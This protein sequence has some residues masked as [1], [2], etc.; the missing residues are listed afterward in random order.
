MDIAVLIGFNDPARGCEICRVLESIARSESFVC[1]S[2]EVERLMETASQLRPDV[3]IAEIHDGATVERILRQLRRV[4]PGTRV[5]LAA[6]TATHDLVMGAIRGGAAGILQGTPDADDVAQALAAVS[7]DG[8]WY[9]HELLYQTLH[10][11]LATPE[12]AAKAA[13]QAAQATQPAHQ[14]TLSS[15]GDMP[16]LTKREE[17]ILTLIGDGLSNK[18]IGRR[19]EISDTTVKTHLHKIYTKLNQSGRYK[20]F[21]AQPTAPAPLMPAQPWGT[22]PVQGA[23]WKAAPPALRGKPQPLTAL[24]MAMTAG[25]WFIV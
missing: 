4:S 25:A 20:A 12:A 22:Q 17:E 1:A 9:D 5:L 8:A 3:V 2:C 10:Q 7:T 21:R 11:C 23:S 15:S 24:Q 13:T 14:P 19:L 6:E 16:L 18:E